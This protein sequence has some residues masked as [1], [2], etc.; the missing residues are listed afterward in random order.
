MDDWPFLQRAKK[1]RKR[2]WALSLA[3]VLEVGVPRH[4]AS[5]PR[6]GTAPTADKCD[7]AAGYIDDLLTS[8]PPGPAIG[9]EVGVL[10]D[11]LLAIFCRT[12]APCVSHTTAPQKPVSAIVSRRHRLVTLNDDLPSGD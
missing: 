9:G 12:H 5:I 7:T 11:G 6:P 10:G 4:P 8:A 3:V 1:K 2:K